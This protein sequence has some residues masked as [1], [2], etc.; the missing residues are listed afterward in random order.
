MIYAQLKSVEHGNQVI[1]KVGYLPLYKVN[2]ELGFPLWEDDLF[3]DHYSG[4]I[5]LFQR[6][7]KAVP[8]VHDFAR[9]KNN[10]VERMKYGQS[11]I[12]YWERRG[13]WFE[14]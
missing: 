12:D 6:T 11:Y 10:K 14:K 9:I 2:Y 3:S 8:V 7:E 13:V 4:V 1:D 5:G